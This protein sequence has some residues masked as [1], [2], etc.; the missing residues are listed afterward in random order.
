MASLSRIKERHT[1]LGRLKGLRIHPIWLIRCL[2]QH[3]EE[4]NQ[5][6]SLKHL[7]ME[8]L[9]G[10]VGVQCR[11][12][13]LNQGAG[14]MVFS[15]FCFFFLMWRKP[16]IQN[17]VRAQKW[18]TGHSLSL[19]KPMTE[20]TFWATALPSGLLGPSSNPEAPLP[21]GEWCMSPLVKV[22]LSVVILLSGRKMPGN[23]WSKVQFSKTFQ[24]T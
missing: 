13:F 5:H 21:V 22:D 6:S 9:V 18:E 14:T 7:E 20:V 23:K 17:A 4:K 16:I 10:A 19:R 12:Y 2:K 8:S 24:I 3:L 1:A 11:Y 15:L